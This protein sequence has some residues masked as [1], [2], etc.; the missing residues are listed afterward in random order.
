MTWAE[1]LAG[2]HPGSHV[3]P[4][5]VHAL[6]PAYDLLVRLT[7]PERR[8]RQAVLDAAQL[9]PGMRVLDVGCGTGSLLVMAARQEPECRLTGADP[10]TRSLEIARVKA[11]KHGA[12]VAWIEASAADLPFPDASFDVALSTLA[13]HHVLPEERGPA[14]REIRRV[15]APGG[16]FHLLDF[17]IPSD[18][19]MRWMSK[20]MTLT[21]GREFVR[22]LL[23]GRV[24]QLVMDAGF[25]DAT[26][27]PP[28]RTPFGT[29]R[30]VSARVTPP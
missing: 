1:S 21:E 2:A 26:Q 25:A 13:L 28:I 23:E 27:H 4:A 6:T 11:A 3:P 17:G 18:R 5:G 12:R 14:L 15:L 9:R 8:F 10:D 19:L 16:T 24:P 7:M 22:D 29:L 20:L 30:L